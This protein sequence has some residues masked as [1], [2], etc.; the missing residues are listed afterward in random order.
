MKILITG[1]GGYIGSN[2]AQYFDGRGFEV[3]GT[4]RDKICGR[5]R[6]CGA[7]LVRADLRDFASLERLFRWDFDYV[8]HIAARASDVGREADFRLENYEAVKRL[9]SL[10]AERGAKRFVYLSTADVYGLRDFC[11]QGED[12]LEFDIGAKNFYP[13]YKILSEIW[14]KENLPP[15][16]FSCV[17]PCVVWGNGDTTITPRVVDFLKKSPFI[18]YF[19]KWKGN[20]RWPLAHVE[21]V[22]KTLH[23]AMILPEAAGRGATVLDSKFTTLKMYYAKIAEQFFPEKKFREICVPYSL[24]YP[25]ARLSSALSKDRPLFDPTLY[26]LDT[27]SRNLDFSNRR[28]LEWL[29]KIGERE[30]VGGEF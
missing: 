7:R 25:L 27:V 18:F 23:A 24:M 13:K 12:G 17:R 19:G 21:N 6:N 20:N 14:L 9:A 22:C 5:A 3:V 10:S 16:K 4:V 30:T 15:E 26:A 11:G 1:A 8:I 2:A 29:G 28:M